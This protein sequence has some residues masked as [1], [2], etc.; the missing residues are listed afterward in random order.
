MKLA[1]ALEGGLAGATTISLLGET[2]RRIDG[3]NHQFNVF[4]AKSLK[5]RFKKA[6]TKKKGSATKQFIQLAGDVLGSAALFGLTKPGKKKNA[7]LRGALLG[8]AAGLGVEF[9][10]GRD[11][12]KAIEKDDLNILGEEQIPAQERHEL[13]K[14]VMRVG[15]YTAGGLIAGKVFQLTG[16]K[17]K[18]K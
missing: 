16:K 9:L 12:K 17:K 18:K 10:H 6:N 4:N 5:K 15:L 7:V 8:A 11:K 14:K 3:S 13:L 1:S 2:L